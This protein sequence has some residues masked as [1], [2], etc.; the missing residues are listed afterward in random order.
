MLKKKWAE[1]LT[2]RKRR[3]RG[4]ISGK[5]IQERLTNDKGEDWKSTSETGEGR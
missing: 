4:Y 2:G 5:T 3:K 1:G